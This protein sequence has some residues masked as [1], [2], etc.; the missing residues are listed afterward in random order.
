MLT[1]NEYALIFSYALINE[2]KIPEIMDIGTNT[3]N[4]LRK[5]DNSSL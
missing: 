1:M 5:I 4:I 3:L 2:R